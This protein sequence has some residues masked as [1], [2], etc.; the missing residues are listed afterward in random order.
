M[1]QIT[2]RVD[3]ALIALTHLALNTGERASARELA[4]GYHLSRPLMANV[5]KE[6]VRAELVRSVRGTK[7]GYELAVDAAELPVGRV[8]ETLEGPLQIASCVG[9]PG[10]SAAAS[11]GDEACCSAVRVCPVKHSVFKI[12]VRIRDVLYA[13]S[14]GDLARGSSRSLLPVAASSV[15][16]ASAQG[17]ADRAPREARRPLRDAEVTS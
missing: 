5:L 4:E 6:L 16:D 9:H 10:P 11:A 1:L 14:I 15:P 17:A 12:H 7:G 13:T 3:Y 8:V 2:K